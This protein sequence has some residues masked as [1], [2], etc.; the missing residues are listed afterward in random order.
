MGD[1]G[2]RTVFP[3][4]RLLW[5]VGRSDQPLRASRLESGEN[6]ILG[7][8]RFDSPKAKYGVIYLASSLDA[9]FGETLA[10][11][12]PTA[13]MLGIVKEEWQERGFMVA[14]SVPQDWRH[15]RIAAQVKVFDDR[16]F[17]DVED[18]A[19][20]DVLTAVLA[21]EL[22]GLKVER[23]DI[24]TVRG[25]DRRV[26]RVISDWIWRQADGKGNR[27]YAGI[28]YL[29]KIDDNWEC[30][31]AFDDTELSDPPLQFLPI[32]QD[33]DSY[34]KIAKKYKLIAH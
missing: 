11:Y 23:L 12:R 4:D 28:R 3:A 1:V 2:V 26:T 21:K 10:R 34:L 29:S 15:R 18:S 31:A 25:C 32:L 14:G 30:W 20:H 19:T 33:M 6:P 8:N 9:C 16:P 24:P 27:V 5:R 22:A 13:E 17:V 7:G